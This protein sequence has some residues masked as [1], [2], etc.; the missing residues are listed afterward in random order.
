MSSSLTDILHPPDNPIPVHQSSYPFISSSKYQGALDGEVVLIT[1]AGRGI[2]RA[3]SLAFA[4]A[5][6]SVACVSRTQKELD[7]LVEDIHKKHSNSDSKARAIAIAGDVTDLSFPAAAV[8]ETEKKLGPINILINNAGLSRVSDLEHEADV[9]KA[10]KVVETNMLGTMSFVQAAI[11]SM[12]ARKSGIIINVVSIIAK[13]T[14]PYFSAYAA[15]KAGI[16]KYTEVIDLELRPKGIQTY[17]VHPCMCLDTTIAVGCM[18][19]EAMEKE[20]GIKKFMDEFVP[21]NTD[22]VSLPADT[23]VALCANEDAKALSGTFV[24]ATY[25]L[26]EQI[27]LAKEKL[28]QS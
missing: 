8:Q 20:Q 27:K 6:A 26:G 19:E 22:K 17:A 12:I 7:T 13:V 24:D 25:D 10:S 23:F 4:A 18:N 5:G 2:G 3:S 9:Q 21:A 1:G 15:A 11:P 14:L 16:A 28:D